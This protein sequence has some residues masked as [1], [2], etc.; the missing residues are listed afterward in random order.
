MTYGYELKRGRGG[1]LAHTRIPLGFDNRVLDLDTSKYSIGLACS[2]NVVKMA[3]DGFGWSFVMF[4][5]YNR[6]VA[7]DPKARA[8]KNAI[9]SMHV[10]ALAGIEQILAEARAHYGQ[11]DDDGPAPR[12]EGI[13]QASDPLPAGAF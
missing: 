13:P 8:T 10:A 2:A 12:Y 9:V 6:T 3:A 5:D 11:P 4:Q 1:L 7:R